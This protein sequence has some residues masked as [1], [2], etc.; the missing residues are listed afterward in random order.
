MEYEVSF[1]CVSDNLEEI[2][3]KIVKE[4]GVIFPNAHLDS[5]QMA[6]LAKDRH[7]CCKE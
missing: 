2:P 1:K 5:S 3:E 7:V 4:S 6:A